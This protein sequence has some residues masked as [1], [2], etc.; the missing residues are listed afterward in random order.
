MWAAR[1]K[2]GCP[3]E[4]VPAVRG[5][6]IAPG[7][8]GQA[9]GSG[10]GPLQVSGMASLATIA[11]GKVSDRIMCPRDH[12]FNGPIESLTW[13]KHVNAAAPDQAGRTILS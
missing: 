13:K 9:S 8:S 11:P 2:A 12:W 1:A 5:W 4:N 3:R 7:G 6:V 10:T